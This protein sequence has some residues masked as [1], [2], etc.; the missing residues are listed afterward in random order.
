MLDNRDKTFFVIW[1]GFPV[2][3]IHLFHPLPQDIHLA[4]RK[5]IEI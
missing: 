3:L 4:D 2:F 1:Q 5:T